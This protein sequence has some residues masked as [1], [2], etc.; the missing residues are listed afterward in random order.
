MWRIDSV[1]PVDEHALL[2]KHIELLRRATDFCLHWTFRPLYP[3]LSTISDIRRLN[4]NGSVFSVEWN[5]ASPAARGIACFTF[6]KPV[7]TQV[8]R[9]NK[10]QLTDIIN[11]LNFWRKIYRSGRDCSSTHGRHFRKRNVHSLPYYN[12]YKTNRYQLTLCSYYRLSKRN[13]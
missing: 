4:K 8:A 10:M 5:V 13:S 7:F 9:L 11:S 6:I 2:H 3:I 12:K 1:A